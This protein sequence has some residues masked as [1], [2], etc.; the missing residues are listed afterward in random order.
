MSAGDHLWTGRPGVQVAAWTG[1]SHTVVVSPRP[2]RGVL[3]HEEVAAALTD[4]ARA[5]HRRAITGALHES[6]LGPF[7]S[8]GFEL[9]E[10]LH[11]LR[12]DLTDLPDLTDPR[13]R[14][15][16]FRHRQAVLEL[17]HLAFEP[18]WTLD[19][20]GLRDAL[21]ATPVTRFRVAQPSREQP[22]AVAYAVT[23]RAGSR[24]YL[25]RLA[26]HPDHQRQGLGKALV[27]DALNWL[28][29]GGGTLAMVN[30]QER[31]HTAL[32][33]YLACGFSLEP[34][35]LSVLSRSLE[36]RDT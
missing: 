17:D 13:L 22:P 21:R 19:R 30:T 23:G 33:L 20:C 2:S 7:I 5:G 34:T 15:G 1:Q 26:V 28:R 25:Q 27:I 16:W 24:G 6:E 29:R 8:N 11:L 36:G 10:R 31:N 32:S 3:A 35:G 18:F 12:H 14:R 9:H 4:L